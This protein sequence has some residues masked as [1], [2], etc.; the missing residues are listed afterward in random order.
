V[1][2]LSL[3]L[4][5]AFVFS[6]PWQNAIQI[7]GSRSLSFAIG[8]IALLFTLVTC[9]TEDRIRKPPV[10]VLA[11]LGFVLWQLTTYLWSID[12][13][14]TVSASI[15]LVQI[16]ALVWLVT[17]L[18]ATEDEKVK[19][20]QA[21][22]FGC[23]VLCLIIIQAYLSGQY[24]DNYRYAP[25]SFSVNES[26]HIIAVGIAMASLANTYRRPGWLFWF[27]IAY[28]PLGLFSV[29]LTASRSGFVVA[30]IASCGV[31]FSMGRVRP[32]YRLIW[33]A[34]IIG[35]FAGLF[36]GLAG[37]QRLGANIQRVTFSADAYSMG[38]LTGRTT[39]WTAGL[40]VLAEHPLGGTGI[41]TFSFATRDLLGRE[42]VAHNLFVDIGTESGLIG[43]A[44]LLAVLAAALGPV[45]V[46]GGD[47]IGLYL[48]LLLVLLTVSFVANVATSKV[49]WFALA[50]VSAKNA[51]ASL[52]P[53]N[54]VVSAKN[55]AL[56]R[57]DA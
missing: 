34:A 40:E 31:V 48:I 27:N 22:V 55:A 53:E 45:L 52:P 50:L 56:P 13:A 43:V 46:R 39:I 18:G 36:F 44:L 1:R 17:E 37:T 14:S 12:S 7:G 3:Y 8:P 33:L 35:V 21:F 29:L 15:S 4:L 47:R 41:G 11:F 28:I 24:I 57:Y 6:L 20:M 5:L 16:L 9:I 32:A 42:K 26:A 19:L 49:L 23:V 30:C 51:T 25:H 54:A 38:T 2:R 10:F